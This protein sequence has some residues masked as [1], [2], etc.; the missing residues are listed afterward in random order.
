MAIIQF[1]FPFRNDQII[2]GRI[3]QGKESYS[4]IYRWGQCGESIKSFE[5]MDVVF[6]R[7]PVMLVLVTRSGQQV[8]VDPITSYTPSLAILLL[9]EVSIS[10]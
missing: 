7:M 3:V 8:L 5:L 9:N 4:R 10:P 6:M 1:I 2:G